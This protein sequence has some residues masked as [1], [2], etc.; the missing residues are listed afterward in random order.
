M[1]KNCGLCI[2]VI[3]STCDRILNST[4]YLIPQC[5]SAICEIFENSDTVQIGAQCCSSLL[6]LAGKSSFMQAVGRH[7]LPQLVSLAVSDKSNSESEEDISEIICDILISFTRTLSSEKGSSLRERNR[8][9][10]M[11]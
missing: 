4:D 1:R 6:A 10:V 2:V 9:E 3:V 11:I 7:L 5:C 8:T